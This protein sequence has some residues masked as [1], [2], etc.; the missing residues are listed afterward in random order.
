MSAEVHLRTNDHGKR[1]SLVA[2]ESAGNADYF[3]AKLHVWSRGF[4][5]EYPFFFNRFQAERLIVALESMISGVIAEGLLKEEYE[6]DHL[7]FR[8]NRLGHVFISG[9]I[10]EHGTGHR[11]SFMIDTDQTVLRP[12]IDDLRAVIAR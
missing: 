5:C 6:D 4:G 10:N 11:L 7:I 12:F 2:V 1:L 3:T 8:N 9:E